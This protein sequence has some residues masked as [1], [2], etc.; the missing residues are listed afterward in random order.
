MT[1]EKLTLLFAEADR[2]RLQPV[3]DA[4]REKGLQLRETGKE[5]GRQAVVLAVLSEAFYADEALCERLLG[6]I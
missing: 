5:P 4:L 1:R 3:L 2:E 6:L